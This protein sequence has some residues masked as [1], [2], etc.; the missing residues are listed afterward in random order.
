MALDQ[1]GERALYDVG[2]VDPLPAGYDRDRAE[3]EYWFVLKR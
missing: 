3:I 2:R 1:S